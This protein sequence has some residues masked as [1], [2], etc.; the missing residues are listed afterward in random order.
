MGYPRPVGRRW[1]DSSSNG[2]ADCEGNF[3]FHCASNDEGDFE[4]QDG[5]L[6]SEL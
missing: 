2:P 5:E 4:A 3:S 1:P 6:G